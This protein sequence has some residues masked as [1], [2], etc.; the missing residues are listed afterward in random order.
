MGRATYRGE[1]PARHAYVRTALT[2]YAGLVET[3]RAGLRRGLEPRSR[4]VDET[5]PQSARCVCDDSKGAR[6]RPPY[7][8]RAV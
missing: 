7:C 6:E 3:N 2:V 8:A 4:R 5:G 1:S